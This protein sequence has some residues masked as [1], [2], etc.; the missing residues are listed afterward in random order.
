MS[1]ACDLA[2][3]AAHPNLDMD[4]VVCVLARSLPRLLGAAGVVDVDGLRSELVGHIMR[5]ASAVARPD[6]ASTPIG[7]D[8]MVVLHYAQTRAREKGRTESTIEDLLDAMAYAIRT[9]QYQ[10][11]GAAL[12]RARWR[13]FAHDNVLA[14]VMAR[15]DTMQKDFA[16]EVDRTVEWR[17]RQ[18]LEQF[19]IEQR[20]IERIALEVDSVSR[21]L[22]DLRP[23]AA[24]LPRIPKTRPQPS[25]EFVKRLFARRQAA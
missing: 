8:V 10:T 19:G 7:D 9:G 6:R 12:L 15:L 22:P 23:P 5:P 4:C 13:I 25:W 2:G 3:A 16:S 24:E 11:P 14:H 17:V 21:R 1:A 18:V 20:A